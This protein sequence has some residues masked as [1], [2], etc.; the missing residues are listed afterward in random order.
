MFWPMVPDRAPLPL[1]IST[2]KR[3]SWLRHK[4]RGGTACPGRISDAESDPSTASCRQ[5][6]IT[7]KSPKREKGAVAVVAQIKDAREADGGVPGLVPISVL[8]LG[9]HQVVDAADSRRMFELS[10][11]HQPE[12][13]PSRLRWRAIKRI[14]V[15]RAGPVR[16]AALAPA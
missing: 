15:L 14:T 6:P 1:K 5:P 7:S 12:Q 3:A 9:I 2:R 4:R 8:F 16:F 11:R 13:G 10:G